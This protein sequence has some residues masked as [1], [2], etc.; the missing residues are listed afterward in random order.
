VVNQISQVFF[1]RRKDRSRQR[2][3]YYV[4]IFIAYRDI[5]AQ[6]QKLSKIAPIFQ[7]FLPFQI[8]KGAVFL[9]LV[10]ALTFQPR[11]VSSAKVSSNYTP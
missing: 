1:Q 2:R 10:H 11:G 3:L 8:L 7:H 9:K 4:A 5:C 6:T